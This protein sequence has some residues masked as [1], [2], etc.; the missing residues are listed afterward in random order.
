MGSWLFDRFGQ[1]YAMDHLAF[2]TA[3]RVVNEGRGGELYEYD[4]TSQYQASI[5]GLR[6]DGKPRWSGLEA[7]RNPPFYA[8]PYTLTSHLSYAASAAIWQ[9]V[10]LGCL[11]VGVRLLQPER[12]WRS[13]LW[14]FSFYPVFC[15]FS[16]G[17]N[18]LLSF[19]FFCG[20]YRLLKENRP[21]LAGLAASFLWFK[22]TLLFGLFVWWA[23][24]WRKKWPCFVGVVCGGTALTLGSYPLVP[25]AWRGFVQTLQSNLA[26]DNFPWAK[27][28]TPRAFF[29]LLVPKARGE[30]GHYSS[31]QY[32]GSKDAVDAGL[33]YLDMFVLL[34]FTAIAVWVFH[35]LWVRHKNNL[36][37]VFGGAVALTL[38]PSAHALIYEWALLTIT[39]ILWWEHA[40]HLRSRW[41]GLFALT[42]GIL[43][44]ATDLNDKLKDYLPVVFQFSVPFLAWA[45]WVAVRWLREP[46]P[47]VVAVEL[48]NSDGSAPEPATTA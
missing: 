35:R 10:S 43:F 19:F 22:P 3:G 47:S 2:Y 40:P 5:F 12:P 8:L 31:D 6:E 15:V 13:T 42:W 48:P 4:K 1:L 45:G 24:D 29:R 32:Q 37:I 44:V 41:I 27:N 18:S 28:H 9:V 17:Q 30:N 23:L 16:Y 14:A 26:F 36:P 11:I 7:F 46:F 39:G 38:W 20:T 34:A 33:K 21:F 25:N